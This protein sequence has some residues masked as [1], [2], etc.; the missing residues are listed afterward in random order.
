LSVAFLLALGGCAGKR[1]SPEEPRIGVTTSWL[2]A[3]VR[4]VA[5]QDVD[6]VSLLPPGDCPGHFDLS[7]EMVRR[8]S[9]CEVL[10]RFEFQRGVDEKLSGLTSRGL[11]IVEVARTDGLCVPE[12]Y[13]DACRQ[14]ADGLQGTS[15]A[16]AEGLTERLAAVE[17]R[18]SKLSASVQKEVE[19]AGLRGRKILCSDHQERFCRWLGLDVAATFPRADDMSSSSLHELISTAQKSN[20]RAVIANLQEGRQAA[21]SIAQRLDVPVIVFSNFPSK[22]AAQAGFEELLLDNV[23]S[24]I[25]GRRR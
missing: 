19:D 20:V 12:V 22:E 10:F 18:L 11:R 23:R 1:R 21:D 5:G 15:A 8:L 17:S 9:R 2:E 16:P 14:I 25:E 24:L 6:V 7:P 3:A 4:D 13:L